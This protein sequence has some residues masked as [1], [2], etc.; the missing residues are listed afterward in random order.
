MN[1]QEKRQLVKLLSEKKK[2]L[3]NKVVPIEQVTVIKRPR[4]DKKY[5][6]DNDYKELV[7]L[8]DT[9]KE[10]PEVS[11]QSI[12]YFI[13]HNSSSFPFLK[14]CLMSI[15]D[16]VSELRCNGPYFIA[17]EMTRQGREI[18]YINSHTKN[19]QQ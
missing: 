16:F 1:N 2:K 11:I 14:K 19:N 15:Y 7:I 8:Y 12:E 13:E 10:K 6:S 3:K 17:K 5:V 18:D 9:M 4:I